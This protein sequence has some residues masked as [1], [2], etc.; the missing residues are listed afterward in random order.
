MPHYAAIAADSRDGSRPDEVKGRVIGTY[1]GYQVNGRIVFHEMAVELADLGECHLYREMERVTAPDGKNSAVL[2][3]TMRD[4]GKVFDLFPDSVSDTMALV[5][6]FMRVRD[7]AVQGF[8][9]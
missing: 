3:I 2:E 7:D 8:D 9:F 4:S 5:R 1:T 6:Y